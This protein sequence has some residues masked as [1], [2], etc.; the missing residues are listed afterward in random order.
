MHTKIKLSVV[1]F[2]LHGFIL[3]LLRRKNNH[4]LFSYDIV[5]MKVDMKV[6]KYDTTHCS[7]IPLY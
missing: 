3:Q 6:Q 7:F 4:V 2:T 1:K 5:D